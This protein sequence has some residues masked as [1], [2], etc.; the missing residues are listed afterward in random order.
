MPFFQISFF[1]CF[2]GGLSSG[3]ARLPRVVGMYWR[4]RFQTYALMLQIASSSSYNLSSCTLVF[5]ETS[6][7]I[8]QCIMIV[9]LFL[10]NVISQ[11]RLFITSVTFNIALL[12]IITI[13]Y[14]WDFLSHSC[15]FLTVVTSF[16]IIGTLYLTVASLFLIN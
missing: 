9:T 3:S 1:A 7:D 10:I 5:Y 6:C 13:S 14:S 16:H 8:T 12:T 15:D 2:A 4:T 11:L